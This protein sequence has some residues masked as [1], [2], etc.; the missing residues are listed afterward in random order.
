M[1]DKKEVLKEI[2]KKLHDGADSEEIKNQFREILKQT[3]AVEISMAEE[4]LIAEGLPK[5]QIQKLC[6]VHLAIFRESIEQKQLDV[7]SG[8]P[9]YILKGEHNIL[10]SA[11]EQ[12]RDLVSTIRPGDKEGFSEKASELRRLVKMFKNSSNHY[13]REENVLF[14]YLEK[15]G[16]TQPPAIMWSEHDQIRET[17]SEIYRLAGDYGEQVLENLESLKENTATLARLL[18]DHFYKE[19]NVLFQTSLR[20]FSNTE[21]SE[22]VS[23]FD[24]VGYC[25]FSPGLPARAPV[26]EAPT[27]A[28]APEEGLIDLGAGRLRVDVL[29]AVLNTLPIDITF[30]D[31]NDEVAYFSESPERIFVRSRAVVGRSVQLCH[32]Q[33]SVH[34]VNRILKDFREGKRNMAEFWINVAGQLIHIRYFA[35]RSETNQYLGCLEVSQ[36]I[37]DIKKIEGEKRLLDDV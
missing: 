5:E 12:L 9:I 26:T 22:I 20:I 28:S 35:V 30:V 4:E 2:I 33:K 19:T 6:D 7:P 23:G 11:A 27:K 34:V 14:P 32:P 17:E 1:S 10:L 37:T 3:T 24:E 15:H 13:L 18:S 36:N 21:W 25:P 16:I 8:H 29:R 31:A